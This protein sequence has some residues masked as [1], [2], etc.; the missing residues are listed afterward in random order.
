MDA[1]AGTLLEGRF[2]VDLAHRAL[3]VLGSRVLGFSQDLYDDN[4]ELAPE[5]VSGL[6]RTLADPCP[7]VAAIAVA[8]GHE[9]GRGGCDKDI[10]FAF[11]LDLIL[12]G[13][14][15]RRAGQEG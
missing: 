12:D 3:H 8:A 1:I 14:E 13:L 9:G 4:A 6:A 5:I 11:G 7:S 2:S 10:E 15:R